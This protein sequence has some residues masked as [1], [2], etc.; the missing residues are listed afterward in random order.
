M[1]LTWFVPVVC[2]ACG[3]TD[4]GTPSSGNN[5]G[6]ETDGG[7]TSLPTVAPPACD[8]DMFSLCGNPSSIV[9]GQVRLAPGIDPTPGTLFL[10]LNH[11]V[12]EGSLG[13]GYH[14]HTLIPQVDL[15]EPVPFAIDMC[16]DGEMWT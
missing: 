2:V 13:G 1:R 5:D 6:S 16:A 7:H 3:G 4:S 10:A 11:E 15:S 9:Q 14:I 12:Y 8:N